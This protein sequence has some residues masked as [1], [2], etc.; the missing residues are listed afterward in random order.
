MSRSSHINNEISGGLIHG[1][2]ERTD[3][4]SSTT[5]DNCTYNKHPHPTFGQERIVSQKISHHYHP[6]TKQIEPGA[7][8]APVAKQF[9]HLHVPVTIHYTNVSKFYRIM[10]L[11]MCLLREKT[12]QPEEKLT[13]RLLRK[14]AIRQRRL[15][16]DQRW[17]RTR[18]ALDAVRR[19]PYR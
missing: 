2:K 16:L 14:L 9:A 13:L 6:F 18:C 12:E 7:H 1:T 4:I 17:I 15:S 3:Q 19:Y 5:T 10:D 11:S 8:L